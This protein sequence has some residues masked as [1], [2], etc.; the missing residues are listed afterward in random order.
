MAIRFSNGFIMGA[1]AAPNLSFFTDL[2]VISSYLRNYMSDF[3]NP[4]FYFYNLDGSGFFIQDGEGDMYDDGNA[5]T[6]WLIS[7]QTYTGSSSYNVSSYPHA[8]NYQTT[9]NP[10]TEDTS[11]GYLSLGYNNPTYLPLTVIG[12]R[13][14]IASPGDPIGFQCG[15]NSG[16]DGQ[17]SHI[18]GNIYSGNTVSGFTVHA[19]YSET[20]NAGDPS[21]CSVFIL[22]GHPDWNSVFGDVFYGGDPDTNG[23]GAFLYTTGGGAQ[24]VLAIKTLLSKDNGVEV[25]FSEVNAVVD[26]FILRIKESQVAPTPTPTPSATP[27]PCLDIATNIDGGTGGWGA[28]VLA[29]AYDSAIINTYGVGSKIVFQNGEVRTITFIDDYGPLYLDISFDTSTTSSPFFPIQICPSSYV[30]PTPT[31]TPTPSPLPLSQ[32]TPNGT[33]GSNGLLTYLNYT[34]GVD[35]GNNILLPDSSGF[36]HPYVWTG[37]NPYNVGTTGYTF[38][39]TGNYAY[40]QD[41]S[42][43][44]LGFNQMSFEMWVK[45]PSIPGSMSLI[46]AGGNNSGGWALRLDSSGNAL[47][48][49]KYNVADQSVSLP[50]TLQADTWYHIAALQGGT[51]LTFMINGVIV[52]AVNNAANNNFSFPSGTVNIAK[53]YYTG[54]NY[55]MTLGYL[56]VYDYC[57]NASD[58]TTEYNNT[59]SGYG[60]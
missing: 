17:G 25:T 31:P 42:N 57:L 28:T 43:Y 30:A 48:L 24:N 35:S 39:G 55:A 40:A 44:N 23:N 34:N 10:G 5:T 41:A 47:N 2:G 49:V 59:K 1:Q 18:E 36:N 60:Y 22:L 58:V 56:K 3:Q 37:T 45:I 21:T 16:A 8:V 46:A 20:Y 9:V 14:T 50:S 6:P 29:V 33:P 32:F 51:S 12:T 19:Y 53:D 26:N 27:I 11:F 7:N 54:T 52:G 15:G 13:A 38:N 4:N